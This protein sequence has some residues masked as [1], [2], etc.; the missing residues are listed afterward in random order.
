MARSKA[1]DW[2]DQL[3]MVMLG[4]RTAWRTELDCSPSELVYGTAL[5]VPGLLVS[6]V[7]DER[8]VLPLAEFVQDLF[9]H[10]RS[11]SPTEMAH[12]A[13]A[14]VHVPSSLEEA[15]FVYIRTDA[16]RAPLVRPYT[17]PFKVIERSAKYFT[18]MKNGRP[19]TVSVDRLKPA[20]VFDHNKG[21]ECERVRKEHEENRT[22]PLERAE[23]EV[24]ERE[25]SERK[26]TKPRKTE[27]ST[28]PGETSEVVDRDYR[29]ALLRD[30]PGFPKEDGRQKRTYV[31]SKSEVRSDTVTTRSGRISRPR[32]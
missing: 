9:N 21:E 10:M 31:K 2:M 4:I 29:A 17:G 27:T 18:L 14:K 30:L 19:D 26:I 11:L 23:R 5:R 1:R 6:E 3:P 25:V 13:T 16:V 22:Q 24:S 8:Q 20:Y 28:G 32:F 12:H 15:N 7:V